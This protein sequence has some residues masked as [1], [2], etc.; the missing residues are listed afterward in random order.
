MGWSPTGAQPGRLDYRRCSFYAVAGKLSPVVKGK[1]H[2]Y[3]HFLFTR[4]SNGTIYSGY[5]PFPSANPH[6][7]FHS[8]FLTHIRFL[9]LQ[10]SAFCLSLAVYLSLVFLLSVFSLSL[11]RLLSVLGLSLVC[12]FGLLFVCHWFV[13]GLASS[14]PMS[15]LGLSLVCL[16]G[17]LFVCLWFVF[18]L[19]LS[20]LMSVFCLSLVCLWSGIILTYV[21]SLSF[22]SFS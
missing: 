4:N 3:F 6:H 21:C 17:L 5:V 18:G 19:A 9:A 15:V 22:F 10:W 11:V 13:F 14:W 8:F 2:W 12:L 7:Y 16:F 1:S 20:W